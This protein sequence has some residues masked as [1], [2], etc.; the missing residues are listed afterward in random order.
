[1]AL[2]LITPPAEEPIT[3]AQAKAHL[4][5]D[6]S[7]EDALITSLITAAREYCESFQNRALITQTWE[8]VLDAWPAFPVTLPL[9]PL[10]SVTSV[11]YTDCVGIETTWAASNYIVD[12]DDEMGGRIGLAYGITL[13][14]TTLQPI[15]GIRIRY[16]AGYGAAA[17]VPQAVKQ[18]MLLYIANRFEN[19]EAVDVPEAVH[20][21]LWPKRVGAV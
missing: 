2:R 3:L 14:T 21:L 18:A 16:V 20:L 13:P 19:R 9:P 11:K 10:Q 4:R 12:T 15:N 17:N 5:V 7:D 8:L 1:M 6:T